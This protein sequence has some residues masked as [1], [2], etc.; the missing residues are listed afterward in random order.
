MKTYNMKEA[1]KVAGCSYRQ[2]G[3]WC[4]H[5]VFGPKF[6]KTGSGYEKEFTRRDLEMVF[7]V[8]RAANVAKAF[9]NR[10]NTD[11]ALLKRI[12]KTLKKNPYVRCIFVVVN[13]KGKPLVYTRLP[14]EHTVVV[15]Y[16]PYLNT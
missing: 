12:V 14:N 2:L 8:A 11:L 13:D 1:A 9:T 5:G 7:V 4:K 16:V 10:N 3:Y 15:I 6:Q